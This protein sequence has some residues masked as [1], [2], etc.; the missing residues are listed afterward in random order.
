MIIIK[1][2][3]ITLETADQLHSLGYAIIHKDGKIIKEKD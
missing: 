1:K 3:G 2:V